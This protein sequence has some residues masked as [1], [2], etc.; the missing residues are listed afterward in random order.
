MERVLP[1]RQG[2]SGGGRVVQ[3][4]KRVTKINTFTWLSLGAAVDEFAH[5]HPMQMCDATT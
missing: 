4:T 3:I 2:G 5:F 1:K